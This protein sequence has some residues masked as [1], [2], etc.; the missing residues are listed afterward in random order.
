MTTSGTGDGGS[1]AP[2]DYESKVWGES[3]VSLRPTSLGALRLRYCLEDLE[4]ARGLLIELGCGAGGFARA[5]AHHRPDLTVVGVDISARALATARGARGGPRYARGDVEAVPLRSGSVD[6]VMFFD[7]LEHVDRPGL[8]L[9][10]AVRVLRG[11]GLLHAF[12]P[13]E[14]SAYTLHGIASRLGYSPKERYAGH[15]QRLSASELRRMLVAT[16]FVVERWR[17][18]GHLLLQAVDLAYFTL[19]AARGRNV[20]TTIEGLAARSDGPGAALLRL[21]VW[22]V[23]AASYAESRLLRAVPASGV[24]VT[25]R[26]P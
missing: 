3:E 18:S 10:E 14:G 1:A 23:A 16:G 17:W 7:V 6:A 11:G 19:L 20:D 9:A 5:I 21:A 8:L 2:F 25:C 22:S 12:V 15:I 24:H 13:C 4:A 26:R